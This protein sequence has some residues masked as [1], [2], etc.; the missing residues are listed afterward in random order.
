MRLHEPNKGIFTN[1][2][3][4]GFADAKYSSYANEVNEPNGVGVNKEFRSIQQPSL[5]SS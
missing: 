4:G 2:N 5:I 3:K 1:P